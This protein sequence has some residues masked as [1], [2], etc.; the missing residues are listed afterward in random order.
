MT[1]VANYF[2]DAANYHKKKFEHANSMAAVTLMHVSMVSIAPTLTYLSFI[3]HHHQFII[4]LPLYRFTP[5]IL[6]ITL[7]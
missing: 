1:Q 7:T 5:K 3:D 2:N 6:K 4:F